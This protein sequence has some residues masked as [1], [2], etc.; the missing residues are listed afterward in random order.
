MFH[1]HP[2]P[3]GAL[4]TLARSWALTVPALVLLGLLAWLP[5]TLVIAPVD[6]DE[7]RFA[8]ATK[9]ML[10]TGD[11]VDI[12]LQDDPRHKKP[13]GIHWLQAGAVTLAGGAADG[14]IWAYRLPSIAGALLAVLA[15]AGLGAAMFGRAVGLLAGAALATSI[16]LGVEARLAKTDALLLGLVVIG[17]WALWTLWAGRDGP[18]QG[19]AWLV[20]WLALAAMAMVKGPI[21]PLVSLLT[22]LGLVA[23]SRRVAWL[24][25]L[26]PLR[27]LL[28]ALLVAAPWYVAIT[29]RTDGAFLRDALG[30]DAIGKVYTV[31][32]GHGAPPGTHLALLMAT[33]WPFAALLPLAGCWLWQRRTDDRA[34]F[35]VAWIVGFWLVMELA[36]TKLPHYVLPTF[37]ALAIAAAVAALSLARR[38]GWLVG[39]PL[40]LT[41]LLGVALTVAATLLPEL[42]GQ[43]LPAPVVLGAVAALVG[44]AAAVAAYRSGRGAT[45]GWALGASALVI[46]ATVYGGLLPRLPPLWTSSAMAEAA[47]IHAPCPA[48]VV[49]SVGYHEPSAVFLIGTDLQLVQAAAAAALVASEPCALAFVDERHDAEFLAASTIPP[50]SLAEVRGWRLNGGRWTTIRLYGKGSP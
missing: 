28:L 40:A 33:A 3:A 7:A 48:P 41:V 24:K 6:R 49:V 43:P 38:P 39:L 12:R 22:I 14:P 27:G 45:S 36:A 30:I 8:Q 37:P 50:R 11:F 19:R 35:L 20:F 34:R 42:L 5:G 25:H 15:T 26:R 9:Q 16:V 47:A 21:G 4:G 13:V 2:T 29:L 32:E 44:L 31:Q 10:A 1:P 18:V 23:W 17:Q 46:Y